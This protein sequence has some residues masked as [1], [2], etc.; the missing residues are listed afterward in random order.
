MKLNRLFSAVLSAALL[1]GLCACDRN[2]PA[3]GPS[4]GVSAS[5]RPSLTSET[6]ETSGPLPES[7]ASPRPTPSSFAQYDRDH[8]LSVSIPGLIDGL[9][10]PVVGATGYTS[11]A[12]PLWPSIPNSPA[13]SDPPSQPG[14][15][16]SEPPAATESPQP[17][18]DVTPGPGPDV[19]P[20]PGPDVTPE[21]GPDVTPKPGP[22][23]TP[24]P[25]PDVTPEPGPDETPE[26]GPDVTP[27]PGPD[28]TPEPGP[29]ES[30]EPTPE[31]PPEPGSDE[32]PE[33]P[34]ESVPSE[35]SDPAS[36]QVYTTAFA[37][38]SRSV[39]TLSTYADAVTVW[40]PGT[41]FVI[42]EESGGWWRVSRGSE[43]G[44]IEHRCCM[45]N[46]PDVIPSI[47]YDD[48]NAYSSL[49]VSSGKDIPGVTGER[50]YHSQVYNIRLDR[51]EF[52]MP[53]LYSAAR[54]ICAA[55][56]RALEEGNCLVVYQAFRPYDT[57]MA[58][59]NGLAQL[60]NVD[61]E[62]NAGL[63]TSPWSMDWFIAAGV[64]GHQRG[65]ALDVS[66]VKAHAAETRY[67]G[68][69][70]YL[71]VTGYEDYEMPT[72][73]HELSIAAISSLSPS[74]S[75]LSETMTE[76]AIAL[77]NY[78]ISSGLSPLAS[79]WW[80][81]EDP[82]A[83]QAASANPS[84]GKYSVTECLSRVPERASRSSL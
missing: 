38:M 21:P 24:G 26:P 12:L 43:T 28:E 65:Y 20:E 58:V 8:R 74:D 84:D 34:P 68:L 71:Y 19:T 47:I 39:R 61:P 37:S 55:Q 70:P 73:M 51:Q 66:M 40:E 49:F 17:S 31:Q 10:L 64:S 67:T 45:I 81:F 15:S 52:V 79:E 11:V 83:M 48:A 32:I 36:V 62:V 16:P 44:W 5:V 75:Q 80:H 50:F 63:S 78:F 18:P 76:P 82:A 41:A 27:E 23:V 42:L 60:A 53:V 3:E 1:T 57:Q 13:V 7:S 30:P 25:G 35:T 56:H 46:L 4:F 54:N 22:D 33:P 9:E 59:V 2:Y 29:D 72:A 6:P 14:P 69:Y 77:R